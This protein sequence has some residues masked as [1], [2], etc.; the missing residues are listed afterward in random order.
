MQVFYYMTDK[1]GDLLVSLPVSCGKS[2]IY[3]NGVDDHV[4]GATF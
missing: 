1:K 3:N 2:I 4:F